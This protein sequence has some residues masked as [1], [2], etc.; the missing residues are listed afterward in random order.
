M[1][2][3]PEKKKLKGR[4]ECEVLE[5]KFTILTSSAA[6]AGFIVD[7]EYRSLITFIA[8]MLR[9]YLPH[10]RIKVQHEISNIIFA[11]DQGLLDVP[12]PVRSP[13][14]TSQVSSITPPSCVAY[15]EDL[16]LSDLM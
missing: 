10:T 7:D 12:Y 15:S 13:S 4:E 5:E 14:P 6:A 2:L 9:K 1:P 11:V 16:N 8:D 3:Q